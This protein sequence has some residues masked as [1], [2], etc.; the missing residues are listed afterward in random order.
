MN[1]RGTFPDENAARQSQAV[2]YEYYRFVKE[3]AADH[4]GKTV[5]QPDF[6]ALPPP[7]VRS[8]SLELDSELSAFDPSLRCFSTGWLISWFAG[9]PSSGLLLLPDSLSALLS[10]SS[11]RVLSLLKAVSSVADAVL[12]SPPV[13]LYSV[14]SMFMDSRSC[15]SLRACKTA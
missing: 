12:A 14:G 8:R 10:C 2:K 9:L 4:S 13:L 7:L 11:G 3:R 15:E 1:G 5:F 6:G